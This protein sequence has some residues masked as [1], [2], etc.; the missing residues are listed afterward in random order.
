MNIND[1][2]RKLRGDLAA[3]PP[4]D[5]VDLVCR[6]VSFRRE[7]DFPYPKKEKEI[8]KKAITK[9]LGTKPKR[10]GNHGDIVLY[11]NSMGHIGVGVYL[12]YGAIATVIDNLPDMGGKNVP[13]RITA[14]KNRMI[15]WEAA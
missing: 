15:Y 12:S 3:N 13:C 2:L 1:S 10:R 7:V 4:K 5:C 9:H 14:P 6:Y 8:T 11:D